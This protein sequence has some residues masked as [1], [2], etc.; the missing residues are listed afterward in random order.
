MYALQFFICGE[1]YLNKF[2]HNFR[3]DPEKLFI[4]FRDIHICDNHIK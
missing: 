4:R 2:N 3:S 1:K